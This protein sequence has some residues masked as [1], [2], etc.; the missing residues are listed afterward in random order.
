LPQINL[1]NQQIQNLLAFL[2]RVSVQGRE[3]EALVG[4]KYVLTQ[5]LNTGKVKEE[6]KENAVPES[7]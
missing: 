2:N 7:K 5:G 6:T 3:A 4:L 1:D